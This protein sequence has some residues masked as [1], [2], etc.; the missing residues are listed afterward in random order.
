MNSIKEFLKNN[1][2]DISLDPTGPNFFTAWEIKGIIDAP[3]SI[4]DLYIKYPLKSL[5]TIEDYYL[6]FLSRKIVSYSDAIPSM[7]QDEHK[8]IITEAVS[9]AETQLSNIQIGT[10]IKYIDSQIETIFKDDDSSD[11]IFVTINFMAEYCTG[12][13]TS[14][15]EYLAD[16][17]GYILINKY[18][19]FE[20]I[21]ERDP[22]LF[23]LV[24]K[25][26]TFSEIDSMRLDTVLNV[27]TH[28][29]NKKNSNLKSIVETLYRV[30]YGDIVT[31]AD[32]ANIDNVM[33]IERKT[34]TFY[35]FLKSIK[36]PCANEFSHVD[37]RIQ[38]L[39]NT[40]IMKNGQ[41]IEYEI[42]VKEI[43]EK[44]KTTKEWELRLLSITHNHIFIDGSVDMISRLCAENRIKSGLMDLVSTN[45]L[46]DNYF[47]LSRQEGLSL[48]SNI[49]SS[50]IIGIISESDTI[51]DY[52]MQ[53]T[54]AMNY[55]SDKVNGEDDHLNDD[56]HY[57]INQIKFIADNRTNTDLVNLLCYGASMFTLS[58]AE[59]LLRI[60]YMNMIKDE[61]YVPSNKAT[62]GDLLNEGNRHLVD[63][64]GADHLKC[65]SFFIV[66]TK[67]SKIG[68][69]LRNSLAHWNSL[70]SEQMNIQF[71]ARC[72]WL[73]TDILNTIFW[74][75][76]KNDEQLI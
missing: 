27:W 57:L 76:L 69:N 3:H 1:S 18:D 73:F 46:T 24:F 70:S 15:W 53:I 14:T 19:K 39:L 68:L 17:H 38:T 35:S 50:T 42:P 32:T 45:V 75:Y 30:L 61:M 25:S 43:V 26:G 13:S 28:I 71:F 33:L 65:L 29:Y 52:L 60:T 36:S 7:I 9:L 12:F 58:L 10:V 2:L 59:K 64:F 48:L 40:S 67:D 44:W 31:L 56:A 4:E 54:S 11:Y 37:T 22:H 51:M 16:K 21:F 62:F 66:Q 23:N 72:L 8:R 49:L 20:T 63:I 34:S 47:T 6:Y 74:H 55:V 5:D 41:V